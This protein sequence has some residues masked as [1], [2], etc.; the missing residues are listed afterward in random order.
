MR[1]KVVVE[2]ARAES[3]AVTLNEKAPGVV[4]VPLIAPVVERLRPSG[5]PLA[6]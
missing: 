6:V 5:R 3:V 4:G 1:V 2:V